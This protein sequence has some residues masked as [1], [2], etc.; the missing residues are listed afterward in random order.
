M[1]K[2][3]AVS[4]SGCVSPGWRG[5]TMMSREL[6]SFPTGFYPTV[7]PVLCRGDAH[8]TRLS[9][10]L[11]INWLFQLWDRASIIYPPPP[12]PPEACAYCEKKRGTGEKALPL[13]TGCLS[14]RFC[15][16]EHQVAFWP[17]HKV[18]C[19]QQEKDRKANAILEEMRQQ[20]APGSVP[21]QDLLRLVEDWQELHRHSLEG[22]RAW[23]LH[24]SDP[25][26]DFRLQY[27][28]FHLKYR[29]ESEG[30][31]STSF[32][33]ISAEVCDRSALGG[34]EAMS[35]ASYLPSIQSA[36]ADIRKI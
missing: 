1:P 15:S 3:T 35:L 28:R 22:A 18:F 4:S 12:P 23:A 17:Q 31:P 2:G 13:C 19:K 21:Y 27:F 7:Q 11:G 36:D 30:N 25:P 20:N 33:L 5:V 34:R 6:P 16:R 8:L 26:M 10:P 9:A 14:V 24:I 29:P 32:T